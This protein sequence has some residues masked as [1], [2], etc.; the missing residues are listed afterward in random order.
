[1]AEYEQTNDPLEPVNRALYEVHDVIDTYALRPLAVAYRH[2]VPAP[3]R[4]GVGNALAN[5]RSPVIL[6]NDALQG[7]S[8]RAGNTLGRFLV[9]STLGVAGILDVATNLGL[10]A[11]EE[12]FGQTLASWGI[13]EGPFLFLPLLGPSNPRDLAGFGADIASQPLNWIGQ[14]DTVEALRW[15]WAGLAAVNTREGL[16]DIV[17]DVEATSLDPY[18]TFRSAYRQRRR[19]L[20]AN[21]D[22]RSATAADARKDGHA[23]T[24]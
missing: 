6:L 7:E 17:D 10:P 23:L 1:V 19:T 13:G 8:E 14:G 15:G 2:V 22:G 11:H 9:N 18:A 5:L 3:V 16:I 4:T 21:R 24:P 12:D 20:I